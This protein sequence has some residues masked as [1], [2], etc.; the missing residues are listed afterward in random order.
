[1]PALHSRVPERGGKEPKVQHRP[2]AGHGHGRIPRLTP[3]VLLLLACIVA[4]AFAA[5]AQ[6][7]DVPSAPAVE[8]Q[9]A[10]PA[11]PAPAPAPVVAPPAT[12]PAAATTVAVRL[13]I[14]SSGSAVRELQRELRRRGLRLTVDGAY[15][16][17][18]KRAVKRIQK[19]FR[20]TATGI[21]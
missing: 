13:R 12:A 9:G 20:M 15:G 8:A 3:G 1:M 16:P 4:G 5:T 10:A 18:T 2:R 21:A 11:P 14:G 19:Q 7:V 17:Q 6:A